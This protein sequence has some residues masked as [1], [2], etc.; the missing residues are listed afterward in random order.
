MS[1]APVSFAKVAGVQR[2][3]R[4]VLLQKL[5]YW[6]VSISWH[7]CIFSNDVKR[8]EVRELLAMKVGNEQSGIVAIF[9]AELLQPRQER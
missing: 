6:R 2:L 1:L 8:S 9:K 7:L 5:D 3:Q 4:D